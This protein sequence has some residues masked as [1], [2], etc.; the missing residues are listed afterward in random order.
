MPVTVG[1][2]TPFCSR[3]VDIGVQLAKVAQRLGIGDE[4]PR[5]LREGDGARARRKDEIVIARLTRGAF[6]D[7]SQ[8]IHRLDPFVA[9]IDRVRPENSRQWHLDLFPEE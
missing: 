9:Q 3:I 4:D 8:W 7:A 5:V 1:V 2:G 6:D